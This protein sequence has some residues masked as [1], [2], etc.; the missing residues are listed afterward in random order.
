MAANI[1]M[2]G[3]FDFRE[4]LNSSDATS[5]KLAITSTFANNIDL[6]KQRILIDNLKVIHR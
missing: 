1:S 4:I 6:P 3:Y 2:L 5:Y